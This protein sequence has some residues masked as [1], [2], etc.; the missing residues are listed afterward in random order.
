MKKIMY[1][2]KIFL[3]APVK[4][5]LMLWIMKVN[6]Q[7]YMFD[8]VIF[9]VCNNLLPTSTVNPLYVHVGPTSTRW[10]T[11]TSLI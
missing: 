5:S 3:I 9:A 4:F 2:E 10:V 1:K 7:I 11:E 6:S 8:V